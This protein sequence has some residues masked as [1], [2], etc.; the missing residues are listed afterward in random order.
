MAQRCSSGHVGSKEG[1]LSFRYAILGV[2]DRKLSK[3][4]VLQHRLRLWLLLF[5]APLP[6]TACIVLLL[7][8][9]ILLPGGDSSVQ[10]D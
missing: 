5:A 10:Q 7:P 4:R 3:S 8:I 2:E 1:S 9:P 6:S